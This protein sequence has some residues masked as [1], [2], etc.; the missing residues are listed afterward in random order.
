MGR[1]REG[2]GAWEGE[3]AGVTADVAEAGVG[4]AG[5]DLA[6]VAVK[7]RDAVMKGCFDHAVVLSLSS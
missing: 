1:G 2:D 7:E 4:V 6:V 3:E 5:E